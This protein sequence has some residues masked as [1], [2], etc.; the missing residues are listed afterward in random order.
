MGLPAKPITRGECGADRIGEGGGEGGHGHRLEDVLEIP[1]DELRS[2]LRSRY[3]DRWNDVSEEGLPELAEELS[4]VGYNSIARLDE[5]LRGTDVHLLDYEDSLD[6][7]HRGY[8]GAVGAVRT[9]LAL[10]DETYREF[11]Y[12]D[13]DSYEPPVVG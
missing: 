12:P 7:A 6:Y 2:Y 11:K 1:L 5:K 10:V 13:D 9:S 4:V 8:F 3:P